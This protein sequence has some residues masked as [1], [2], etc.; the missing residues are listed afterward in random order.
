MGWALPSQLRPLLLMQL[1]HLRCLGASGVGATAA[2]SAQLRPL[3][4]LE[5]ALLELIG[6]LQEQRLGWALKPSD[7]SQPHLGQTKWFPPSLLRGLT[8]RP[9]VPLQLA[10]LQLALRLVPLHLARQQ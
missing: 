9:L 7:R 3:V 5:L 10:P 1:A 8:L 2:E 4:L 6:D